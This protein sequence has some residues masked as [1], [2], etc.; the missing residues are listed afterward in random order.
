MDSNVYSITQII[1]GNELFL[2]VPHRVF[3]AKRKS[4]QALYLE[5][6]EKCVRYILYLTEPPTNT[7]SSNFDAITYGFILREA[8]NK[9]MRPQTRE[10]HYS[11]CKNGE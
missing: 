7:A 3:S 8:M 2:V 11:V 9:V 10:V 4:Q 1:K 5:Q 6:N